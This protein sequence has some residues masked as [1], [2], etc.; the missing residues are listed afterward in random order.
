MAS[1]AFAVVRWGERTPTA[2]NNRVN[3]IITKAISAVTLPEDRM[4]PKMRAMLEN[5][6]PST[7]HHALGGD[8]KECLIMPRCKSV[9]SRRS[10]LPATA[11]LFNEHL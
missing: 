8:E 10:F 5:H 7:P 3:E 4:Q 9:H 1:A 6:P 11:K 2:D